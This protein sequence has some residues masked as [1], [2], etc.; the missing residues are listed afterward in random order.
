MF[1]ILLEE[2][3][4]DLKAQRTRAILTFLA[5]A[6]GALA[7]V[8]LLA[9]GEGLKRSL[10]DG[11]LGAGER[12]FMLYG[13]ETSKTFAGLAQGRRIRLVEED[14]PLLMSSIPGIDRGSVSYGRW[15]AAISVGRERTTTFLEGV[16]PDH[17][18]ARHMEAAEGGRFIS[19]H[20]RGAEAARRVPRQ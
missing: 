9:F 6:W 15:G 7:I 17:E 18:V 4:G 19:A 13:G 16:A 11:L 20:R 5:V 2:F 3:L 12:I 14:L 1:R 10:R 8:L